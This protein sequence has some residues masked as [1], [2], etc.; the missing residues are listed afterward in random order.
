MDLVFKEK[1][2]TFEFLVALII[3]KQKK[4]VEKE[5]NILYF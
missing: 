2:G 4:I 3:D 5:K 1:R